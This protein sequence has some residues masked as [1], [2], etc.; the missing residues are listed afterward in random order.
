M[1]MDK[2][3]FV[4]K[5]LIILVS[6]ILL[7]VN[8]FLWI[9]TSQRINK[10]HEVSNNNLSTFITNNTIGSTPQYVFSD[11]EDLRKQQILDVEQCWGDSTYPNQDIDEKVR[12]GIDAYI[13]DIDTQIKA[14]INFNDPKLTYGYVT[15]DDYVN[16]YVW[17][18]G[19]IV[20]S[21]ILSFLVVA[22]PLIMFAVTGKHN[23]KIPS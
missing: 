14:T 4:T 6:V 7:S 11:D 3:R 5:L 9:I 17:R 12:D 20:S 2:R 16:Y 21:I 19:L 13:L 18:N 22:T 8:I 23:K 15:H 1:Q 10:A